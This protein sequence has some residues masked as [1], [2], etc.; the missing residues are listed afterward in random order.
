MAVQVPWVKE[1]KSK[2]KNQNARDQNSEVENELLDLAKNRFN[3]A[4]TGKVAVDGE[5]LHSRWRRFDK[6]YRSD[7]WFESVPDD[8]STPVLNFTFALI[9]S[10]IPRLTDNSPEILVKARLSEKDS[11]LA[12]ILGTVLQHIWYTNKMQ[13]QRITETAL[14]MLKY[15]TAIAKVVWNPDAWDGVGEVE[16]STIHPINFYPDPR[17]YTIEDMEYYFIRMAKPMEYFLRRWPDK[18]K[19]VVPD[20][21]WMDTEELE[22]RGR[23]S[24]EETATLTEYAFRDKEGNVCIMYYVGDVV[25]GVFGGEYDEDY[26]EEK[27]GIPVYSHNKF[28]VVRFVDYHAEKEFWGIGEIELIDILQQL[29]NAYEAQIVDNTRLMGNAQW[30]VNK[31]MSG[32]DE[33]DSWIFDNMPG[34]TIFTHNGGVDRFPG[35]PIPQHIPA[36]LE[37]LIEWM[38]Q[39]LGVHDVV[40]GRR[41]VGVRSAS[42]IIALQEAGSI[43][44]R[45][46][47]NNMGAA[48][49]EMAEQAISLVLEFYD[50]PRIVRIAGASVPM[51]L[52][53]REVL[54]GRMLDMA[55]EMGILPPMEQTFAPEMPPMQPQMGGMGP[56]MMGMGPEMGG[57]PPDMG[58]S[59]DMG[60]GMGPEMP[61]QE[62]MVGQEELEQALQEI[63]FPEFDVEVKVGPSVPYSQ[64]LLYEEAKEFYQL[65]IIDRKAVLE[66]TNF[67]NKEEIIARMEQEQAALMQQQGERMGERTF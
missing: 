21:D 13:E 32:L 55:Q 27:G 43:R 18:G 29:I 10:L 25:L 60:M 20:S 46:K 47:A 4:D 34:R 44:V 19:L 30:I 48:I 37:K 1:S 66:V 8:R 56:D 52:D 49:R 63:K 22:G 26:D 24:G 3:L 53:V 45:E 35:V 11:E 17:A 36:H 59:P 5:H 41:P 62:P 2:V 42:G 15:G 38:E 9:R 51:S 50:E 57:M 61:P 67:P 31:T 58:M 6:I 16:Y 23:D 14:H 65:G 64:A 33:S 54:T 39:I 28:P 12:E 7:Q 40:Q